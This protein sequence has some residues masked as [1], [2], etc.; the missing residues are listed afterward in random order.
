MELENVSKILHNFIAF[1]DYIIFTFGNYGYIFIIFY[2]PTLFDNSTSAFFHSP[3]LIFIIL[4]KNHWRNRV[5]TFSGVHVLV[6]CFIMNARL[7]NSMAKVSKEA[8]GHYIQLCLHVF[9]CFL[10]WAHSHH[11]II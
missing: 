9:A 6:Q 2:M 7:Y 4:G 11:C 10:T 1:A 3:P 5:M 8:C